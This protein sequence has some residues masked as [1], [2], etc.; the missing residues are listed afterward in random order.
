MA[1][2]KWPWVAAIALCWALVSTSLAVF[3]FAQSREYSA[4]LRE[5]EG[6]TMRVNLLIDYG[7]GTKVWYNGTLVPLGCNL[8]NAT[9]RVAKIESTYWEEFKAIFVDAINGVFNNATHNWFWDYWDPGQSKWVHGPVG[10]DLYL[11]RPREV[12]RWYYTTWE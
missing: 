5:Y 2:I 8:L 4:L 1:E 12:V 11:L 9:R 7:N 10:A 6:V 3:Y